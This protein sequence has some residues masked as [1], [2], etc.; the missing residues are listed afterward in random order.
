M[1]ELDRKIV[2][3]LNNLGSEQWDSTWLIVTNQL[4][5]WPLFVFI[6][7][8]IFK[9]FGLKRGMFI[10]FTTILLVF[11]SDQF[12]NIIKDS[13]GR[14]RPNNDLQIKHLL[15]NIIN[16]TSKSFISGHATTSTFFSVYIILLIKDKVKYI[17][18]LLIFPLLFSYSR[19]YLGVHFLSDVVVGSFVGV[20]FGFLYYNIFLRIDSKLFSRPLLH[21]SLIFIISSI[22]PD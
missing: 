19:L 13:V 4:Y 11:L 6:F 9:F 1:I 22:I 7:Y 20:V 5:W 2:I 10:V 14:L 17:Y 3:F 12:V 16:P 8:Y 21:N 15:R 18:L